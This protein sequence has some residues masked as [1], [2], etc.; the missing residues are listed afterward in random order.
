MITVNWSIEHSHSVELNSKCKLKLAV[1]TMDLAKALLLIEKICYIATINHIY[2]NLNL[3]ETMLDCV[4]AKCLLPCSLCC[5]R[6]KI[7]VSFLK[8]IDNSSFLQSPDK[9]S[10]PKVLKSWKLMKKECTLL[11][12][13][14]EQFGDDLYKLLR[15]DDLYQPRSSYFPHGLIMRL[16]DRILALVTEDDL[17]ELLIS[18]DW[19]FW[20]SY[21]SRLH[22]LVLSQQLSIKSSQKKAHNK[23]HRE[24]SPK[25]IDEDSE[26]AKIN[27]I[28]TYCPV[29]PSS[30]GASNDSS[31]QPL[32]KHAA[33]EDST[34]QSAPQCTARTR[35]TI[36]TAS[37][38]D[39]MASYGPVRTSQQ[40]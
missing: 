33:L 7:P 23:R 3:E 26:I 6:Y 10:A 31:Q 24:P 21:G 37:V 30:P 27:M 40:R 1:T 9:C 32:R 34:N 2:Q 38:K 15:Y 29:T 12:K 17:K 39:I 28:A 16:L 18:E 35:K 19:A 14:L 25:S 8:P 4:Q 5:S 20:D 11:E 22:E 36:N 13:E